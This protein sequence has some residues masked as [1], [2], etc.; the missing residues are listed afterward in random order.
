MIAYKSVRVSHF[1]RQY[2]KYTNENSTLDFLY[3][4]RYY[5]LHNE[6]YSISRW[7]RKWV[8]SSD[9]KVLSGFKKV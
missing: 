9:D 6:W 5:V 2:M 3:R 1:Y 8:V 4:N 7:T